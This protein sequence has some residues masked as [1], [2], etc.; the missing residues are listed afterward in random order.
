MAVTTNDADSKLLHETEYDQDGN[1]SISDAIV[2]ALAEV[3]SVEPENLSM[4]LYDS[5]DSDALDSLYQTAVERPER[6][7]VAFTIDSYEV[8]VEDGG[9]V[10]VRERDDDRKQDSR[11]RASG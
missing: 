7:R 1:S 2:E 4:R 10:L 3:E 6:L 8:V 11:S 5:V 9:R